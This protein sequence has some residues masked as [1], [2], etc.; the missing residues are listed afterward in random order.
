M[1]MNRILL[2]LGII[3]IVM[4]ASKFLGKSNTRSIEQIEKEYNVST[5]DKW[6][7]GGTLHKATVGQWKNATE[8][9]KLATC[10]DFAA[11]ADN[12]VSMTELK[13]RAL[14]LMNCIN[15]ATRGLDELNNEKVASI[16]SMCSI[17]LGYQ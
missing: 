11:V 7:E 5:S 8:K 12:T 10:A 2:F 17:T 15:E 3:T 13:S 4:V 6:Y 16:A 1:K 9:N 14:N